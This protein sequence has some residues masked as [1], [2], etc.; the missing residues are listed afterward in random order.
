MANI[1]QKANDPA[2]E[3]LSAIEDALRMRGEEPQTRQVPPVEPERRSVPPSTDLFQDEG[4]A[5]GWT[6]D[7]PVRRAANDD[8]AAIGKI[9]QTL[10]RRPARTPYVVAT[11][12][13]VLWLAGAVAFAVVFRAKLAALLAQSD[14]AVAVI[15]PAPAAIIVPI[16]VAYVLAHTVRRTHD[17]RLVAQTMA[18]VT[19]RLA[20]PETAAREQI[21]NV[22]Q[23]VR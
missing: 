8:R 7:S 6:E 10:Q 23:A 2:K 19:M 4:P 21:V 15:A 9:L 11:T 1:P 20:E 3:A 18:E 12:L 5:P 14:L 22:G 13:S 17:L 16:A